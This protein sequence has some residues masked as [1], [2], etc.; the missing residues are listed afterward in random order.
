VIDDSVDDA[1]LSIDN[2]NRDSKE[3]ASSDREGGLKRAERVEFMDE[4]V[5]Q[6]S[7]NV[8][9]FI[10]SD[11]SKYSGGTAGNKELLFKICYNTR[12]NSKEMPSLESHLS[13]IIT[14][15]YIKPANLLVISTSNEEL[16]KC[17]RQLTCRTTFYRTSGCIATAPLT[18]FTASSA[19]DIQD[20]LEDMNGVSLRDRADTFRIKELE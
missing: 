19:L 18:D 5:R 13:S 4:I 8:G 16:L 11:N 1:D 3:N 17:G 9:G 12:E 6:V 14:S 10:G 2:E 7:R 15:N 20:I